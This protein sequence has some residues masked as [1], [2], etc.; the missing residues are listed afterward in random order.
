MPTTLA[1]LATLVD[2][3]LT[4]DATTEIGGAET[5]S[6]ARPGDIT[7]FDRTEVDRQLEATH[8][9]AIV[10]RKGFMPPQPNAIQVD[11]VHAAFVKIVT[12]FRPQRAT[13]RGDVHANA[14]I[15]ATATLGEN[16]EIHAFAT[17][18]D[19]VYIGNRVTIHSGVHIAAGCTVGDDTTIFPNCVLY[20]ETTVGE[21]CVIHAGAVL[22]AYGFGYESSTGKHVRSEQLGYAK[23]EDDVEIGAGTTIDRG[24]YG[25]TTIGAG[26]KIDNL[27]MIAHNCQ[28]GQHN[29]LCSQVGIAG[30]TTTGD[31]V[32]M[33]GQVGVRDHVHIGEHAILG[34]MAG[35][36]NDIPER[37]S[38]LGAPAIPLKD[39]RRQV[40][41]IARLPEMRKQIQELK[42]TVAALEAAEQEP[43]RAADVQV[44]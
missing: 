36:S 14:S 3:T 18:G 22:G 21:R 43:H 1:D 9:A 32:V 27:V 19:D 41:A 10:V 44:A 16:I 15:S 37:A 7:L 11:D 23:I 20:E 31:Y 2:G 12:H 26:T 29:M 4:G 8:A 30:S 33:A 39:M 34:A 25:A 40:A 35:V 17:I 6:A 13:I 28:I 42:R 5:L 38:V 24:T